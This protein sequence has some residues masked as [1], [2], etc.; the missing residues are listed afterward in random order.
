MC[1]CVNLQYFPIQRVSLLKIKRA[2]ALCA[3]CALRSIIGFQT[4]T[5]LTIEK[6]NG[7]DKTKENTNTIRFSHPSSR[8][9]FLSVSLGHFFSAKARTHIRHILFLKILFN[10]LLDSK[11]IMVLTRLFGCQKL[12]KFTDFGTLKHP[13]VD[14]ELSRSMHVSFIDMCMSMVN[15]DLLFIFIFNNGY[16]EGPWQM[17][18]S[19]LICGGMSLLIFVGFGFL[20]AVSS[21]NFIY[22]FPGNMISFTVALFSPER[23]NQYTLTHTQTHNNLA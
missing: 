19:H 15:F 5:R 23:S 20:V 21:E 1:V 17:K 3:L 13:C 7:A 8:V 14:T 4:T 2:R 22:S 10:T 16:P 18:L 11:P 12:W 6:S 9:L